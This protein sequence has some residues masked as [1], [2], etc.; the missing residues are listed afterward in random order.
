MA[1]TRQKS[2]DGGDGDGGGAAFRVADVAEVTEGPFKGLDGPVVAIDDAEKT[3]T[4]TLTVM[5]RPTPVVLPF[6][7]CAKVASAPASVDATGGAVGED[8]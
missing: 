3:L 4:L 6:A 8:V 1:L 5:G 7:Q 2:D